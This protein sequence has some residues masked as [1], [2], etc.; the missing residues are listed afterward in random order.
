MKKPENNAYSIIPCDHP[1]IAQMEEIDYFGDIVPKSWY[2]EIKRSGKP[3][4]TAIAI[5]ADIVYWY[6]PSIKVDSKTGQASFRK[7]FK[8]KDYLQKSYRE[9]A[10]T[11]G[12][13]YHEVRSAVIELEKRGLIKRIVRKA[14][15][16]NNGWFTLL[17]IDI[18]PDAVKKITYKLTVKKEM[19]I[20]FSQTFP[21][22]WDG[23]EADMVGY[24]AKEMRHQHSEK[25]NLMFEDNTIAEEN[26]E[27]SQERQG[28][29][30]L[31][32]KTNSCDKT[33][34]SNKARNR[35]S[36]VILRNKVHFEHTLEKDFVKEKAPENIC[37]VKSGQNKRG[38]L[39]ADPTSAYKIPPQACIKNT[40][41]SVS[42]SNGKLGNLKTTPT[43]SEK[44]TK[45]KEKSL[46]RWTA[47]Y[48]QLSKQIEYDVAVCNIDKNIID[49][50]LRI[51]TDTICSNNSSFAICSNRISADVVKNAM[52]KIDYGILETTV[53]ILSDYKN[54]IYSLT[55]FILSTL[56]MSITTGDLYWENK[57]QCNTPVWWQRS[58][59]E[60]TIY[61]DGKFPIV[62]PMPRIS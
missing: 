34:E 28:D 35:G 57:R 51:A 53:F 33:Q 37:K 50:I 39:V 2:K 14:R 47:V 46:P 45:R 32:V 59:P 31:E 13:G 44:K 21:Q 12:F 52:W 20:D 17:F 55:S 25:T 3:Y 54:K 60:L 27:T 29:T 23:T 9:M 24:S 40:L 22:N 30:L 5:L 43:R 38:H 61:D 26:V 62:V 18:D 10:D 4:Q 15:T 16:P 58:N 11:F 6:R 8:D 49:A 56:Y 7:K 42:M 36:S 48:S 1:K 41:S 19:I